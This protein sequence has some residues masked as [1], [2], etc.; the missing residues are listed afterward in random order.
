MGPGL[1]RVEQEQITKGKQCPPPGE[2]ATGVGR[3]SSTDER[4]Y[5]KRHP[6]ASQGPLAMHRRINGRRHA[7][8]ADLSQSQILVAWDAYDLHLLSFPRAP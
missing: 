4:A 7:L 8:V 6:T 3:R 5:E 1:P 2:S